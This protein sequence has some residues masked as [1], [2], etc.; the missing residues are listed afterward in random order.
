M[1]ALAG[2][3]PEALEQTDTFFAVPSGRLKLR[4][5]GGRAEL[6]FYRRDDSPDPVE[7]RYERVRVGDAAA[8]R[9]LLAEALGV[10]GV[11]AKRRLV[12]RAGRTRI[13]LDEVRG[14]G[15]FLE[16]EVELADGG[17]AADGGDEAVRLMGALG[18]A[19]EALVAQAYIDLLER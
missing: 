2:G 14:L 13:H 19:R 1:E 6:I 11:V 15:A 10:R 18:I 17:A 12:F 7:S 3:H 8:L 4:E 9:A 5:T 16:L